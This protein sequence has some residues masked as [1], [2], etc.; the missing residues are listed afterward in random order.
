MFV[1]KVQ[2]IVE[3]GRG[4][5]GAV[6][7]RREK[8]VPK[9]GPDGGDGGWGGN[10]VLEVDN[11]INNLY[12]LRHTPTIRAGNGKNGKSKKMYGKKGKTIVIKVPPGTSVWNEEEK[13]IFDLLIP[14]DER[15]IALGGRGGKGNIHFSTSKIQHPEIA[16]KGKPG[17]KKRII[18]ELKSIA[19]VG[20]VGYPNVGKST[21]LDKISSATP[22][23]ANYPF[24]TLSPNLGVVE[25]EDFTR[26]TFADIPGVIKGAS[27]GKGLGLEFLRH[28]ERTRLLLIFL[29]ITSVNIENDYL[30]ILDELNS[31]NKTLTKYPRVIAVNKID[32]VKGEIKKPALDEE[33]FY[34]S[35]LTGT[36]I[37]SILKKI[38]SIIKIT[39]G[40]NVR[41]KRFC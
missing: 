38:L 2:L 5:D 24:T 20:I 1:D 35:A 16:T 21:F 31:Y 33:I 30:S 8:F 15:I 25:F 10:V 23:I 9:G 13:L 29:D 3:S 14:G 39:G 41:Q 22:K 4:G 32:L 11:N 27:N 7:F 37:A 19:D 26:L 17:E 18:L 34:I 6:S 40:E 36:G 12:H 28:I